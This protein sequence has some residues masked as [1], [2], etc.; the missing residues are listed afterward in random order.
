MIDALVYQ[1]LHSIIMTQKYDVPG[2]LCSIDTFVFFQVYKR[3]K[4]SNFD[5]KNKKDK[6]AASFVAVV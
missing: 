4:V 5:S 1:Q 3:I 2:K 6:F